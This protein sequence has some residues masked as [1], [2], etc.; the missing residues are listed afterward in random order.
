MNRLLPYIH[1]LLIQK[2]E[3]RENR[4]KSVLGEKYIMNERFIPLILAALLF[5]PVV[6]IM[7]IVILVGLN[8]SLIVPKDAVIMIMLGI[9][10]Y[11]LVTLH[12]Q[13][14][15]KQWLNEPETS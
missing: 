6:L 8:I 15:F 13:S 12:L 14:Y 10:A 2:S 4:L 7:T 1:Y 3:K 9:L 5:V 11:L